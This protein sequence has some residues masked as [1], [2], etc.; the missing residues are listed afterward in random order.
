[1]LQSSLRGDIA[2]EVRVA[3]GLWPVAIDNSEFELALLNLAVNAR[4]AMSARRPPHHQRRQRHRERQAGNATLGIDRRLRRGPRRRH[5]R[6]HSAR[7]LGR[8]FEPFFT[9]KEVGKGTGLGLSQVYGFARQAGGT[10]TVASAPGQGTTVTLYLPRSTGPAD[11]RSRRPRC[12]PPAR[13]SERVRV[14]LVEDNAD[15]AEVTRGLLEE[16]GYDVV[17]AADVAAGAR[18]AGRASRSTWC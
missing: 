7:V 13:L 4:D 10:A 18:G 11:R 15:V 2:V 9:T 14:L 17:H 6:R 16:L 8:V 3:P 1:M 5:R 12:A